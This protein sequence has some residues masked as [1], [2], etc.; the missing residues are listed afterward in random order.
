MD[1]KEKYILLREILH[2]PRG[3]VLSI[4]MEKVIADHMAGMI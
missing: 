2:P 3:N 1:A 4:N